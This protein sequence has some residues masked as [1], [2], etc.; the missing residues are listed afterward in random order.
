MSDDS[1]IHDR[2]RDYSDG[3]TF[4]STSMQILGFDKENRGHSAFEDIK[5]REPSFL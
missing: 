5:W 4:I 3:S 1:K 2:H